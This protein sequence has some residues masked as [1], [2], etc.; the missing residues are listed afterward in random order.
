MNFMETSAQ[1]SFRAPTPFI[2]ET[3][4]AA[5]LAG[6]SRSEYARRAIE[7]MNRRV[8]EERIATLSRQLS[9]LSLAEAEAMD[10]A[11]ADGLNG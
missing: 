9:A 8:M 3:E 4:A 5:R 7:A 10:N 11:S 2:A 6:L 1:F